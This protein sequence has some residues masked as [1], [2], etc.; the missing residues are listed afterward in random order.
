MPLSRAGVM[1]LWCSSSRRHRTHRVLCMDSAVHNKVTRA[2]Q[3][4]C[5]FESLGKAVA[6][7][8]FKRTSLAFWQ[9]VWH[10]KILLV[11][12]PGS[13]TRQELR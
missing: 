6:G 9:D 7:L 8:V 12:R 3:L 1:L 5:C 2:K 10:H 11:L 4:H 13:Y